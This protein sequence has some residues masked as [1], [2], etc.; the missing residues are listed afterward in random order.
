[1]YYWA[2]TLSSLKG[3]VCPLSLSKINTWFLPYDSNM[4]LHHNPFCSAINSCP[5]SLSYNSWYWKK[6]HYSLIRFGGFLGGVGINYRPSK[7]HKKIVTYKDWAPLWD[8]VGDPSVLPA[9][10]LSKT[11]SLSLNPGPRY[12]VNVFYIFKFNSFNWIIY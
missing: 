2:N 4:N 11:L 9:I 10:S 5:A 7:A 6:I 12:P 8:C 3:N 1:M